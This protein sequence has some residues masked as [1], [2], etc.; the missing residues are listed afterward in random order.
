MCFPDKITKKLIKIHV[1]NKICHSALDHF[2]TN[3]HPKI[4]HKKPIK[5]PRMSFQIAGISFQIKLIRKTT[6]INTSIAP[7]LARI[8]SEKN[9]VIRVVIYRGFFSE[10]SFCS[11]GIEF[12][13]IFSSGCCERVIFSI[14]SFS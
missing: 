13:S 10:Y 9:F 8:F 7:I 3:F 2:S 4:K 6:P 11:I 1:P 14:G 12:L 5:K